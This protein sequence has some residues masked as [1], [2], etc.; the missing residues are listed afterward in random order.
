M[1]LPN[2]QNLPIHHLAKAFNNTATSYKFYWFYVLIQ[3]IK[4]EHEQT[5][6]LELLVRM[7]AAVW[8][9]V[10]YYK[11]SYGVQDK[12][13]HI[14]Q[15]ALELKVLGL[16]M[17][18]PPEK[19]VKSIL[20]YI[21][22]HPNSDLAKQIRSL[23]E[24]V[25]YRFVRPWCY[26]LIEKGLKDKKVN[27]RIQE[28]F[29]GDYTEQTLQLPYYFTGKMVVFN[30]AWFHYFRQHLKIME[31]FCLWN[32][33]KYVQKR[34]PNVPNIVS[35]LFP[36]AKKDRNLSTQRKFW[37]IIYT[38]TDEPLRCLFSNYQINVKQ[39]DLDHFIPWSFV[40]HNQIWNLVPVVPIVNYQK[41]DKLPDIP[42][43]IKGFGH[44]QYK[45]FNIGLEFKPKSK[46][47]ED[48]I[49]IVG[50]SLDEIK[51]LSEPDFILK[52]ENQIQPLAQIAQNM[53]FQNKWIYQK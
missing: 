22:N 37:N 4:K 28:I 6:I 31:D 34:N 50:N 13:G 42:T 36:P 51:T 35:K 15:S 24:Y 33:L 8:Y 48:Y 30:E 27:N 20:G 43:Y 2:H 29:T 32:L 7:V 39:Y 45:A 47:L 14:A 3:M 53:G 12:L 38:Y 52:L 18:T 1:N 17:N 21:I 41:S 46:I 5:N 25:P 9:P 16:S 19:V 40:T 10:H 23:G 44:L 26:D 49:G 11:L